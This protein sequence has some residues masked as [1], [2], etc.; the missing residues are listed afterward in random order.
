MFIFCVFVF[1]KERLLLYQNF[2][3]SRNSLRMHHKWVLLYSSFYFSYSVVRHGGTMSPTRIPGVGLELQLRLRLATEAN[4]WSFFKCNCNYIKLFLMIFPPMRV[5]Y[6]LLPVQFREYK[7]RLFH[8]NPLFFFGFCF[9]WLSVRTKLRCKALFTVF[10]FAFQPVF[11]M[12]TY[13]ED[14]E[15]AEVNQGFVHQQV[16]HLSY[17][18]LTEDDKNK[19][20]RISQCTNSLPVCAS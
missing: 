9:V 2:F 18:F 4:D 16:I 3:L 8:Y 19:L 11:K 13:E 7:K 10:T 1:R 5:H 17:T 20:K 6:R 12:E 15:I 14:M